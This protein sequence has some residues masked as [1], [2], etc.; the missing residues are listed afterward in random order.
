[1]QQSLL[2]QIQ[3]SQH[4]WTS[5]VFG[6]MHVKNDRF[7]EQLERVYQAIDS[8]HFFAA[9]Y[10][11]HDQTDVADPS[12]FRLPEGRTLQDYLTDKRYRKLQRILRKAFQVDLDH[13]QHILPL[14]VVNLITQQIL[15]QNQS[16]SLDEHLWQYAL[17]QGKEGVGVEKLSEQTKILQQIPIEEQVNMLRK[18]G[19]NVSNFRQQ[20]LHTAEV[21]QSGDI[22][23]LYQMTKKSTGKMRKVLLYRRNKIM[24]MRIQEWHKQQSVCAAIGA[25]HLAGGKG[26]L[27]YLKQQGFRMQPI[28]LDV[29]K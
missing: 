13:V 26:V 16:V 23:K 6:T 14:F 19:K 8:C 5:Y 2:W 25:A 27:R 11:F 3:H 18:I 24:A 15:D 22:T 20:L 17:K 10:D 28:A 1:M 7:F 29:R 9:E 4:D 12:V 21:Y